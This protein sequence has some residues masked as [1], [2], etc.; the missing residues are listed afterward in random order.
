M[1]H[2]VCGDVA[3]VVQL[4][5]VHITLPVDREARLIWESLAIDNRLGTEVLDVLL[6]VLTQDQEKPGSASSKQVLGAISAMTVMIETQKVKK[7]ARV[8]LG[9]VV[10]SLVM[11]LSRSLGTKYQHR[12]SVISLSKGES[13][14]SSF[15][16][17]INFE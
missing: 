6:E 12:R 15:C 8:K 14:S 2:H 5:C 11:L 7:V 1:R 4:F 10:S 3:S 17:E 9:R 16:L 13:G